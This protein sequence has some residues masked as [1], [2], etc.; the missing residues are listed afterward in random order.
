MTVVKHAIAE[1]DF[2]E[3]LDRVGRWDAGIK[4]TV[5]RDYG[6]AK[7]VEIADERGASLDF[8]QVLESGLKLISKYS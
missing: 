2:V 1:H 4:G 8:V 3:L 5:V 7:L 6:G